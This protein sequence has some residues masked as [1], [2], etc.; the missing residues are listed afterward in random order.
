VD[1]E[2]LLSL[3]A[4]PVGAHTILTRR[5]VLWRRASGVG[6]SGEECPRGDGAPGR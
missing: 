5:G 1:T 2:G 3:G 6:A 4:W